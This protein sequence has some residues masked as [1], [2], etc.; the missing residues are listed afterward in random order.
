ME[1]RSYEELCYLLT[2]DIRAL[3]EFDR[4]FLIV[5]MSGESRFVG[6]S[7]QPVLDKKSK[8]DDELNR[9]AGELKELKKPLLLKSP[10]DIAA[11]SDEE[12]APDLKKALAA[13]MQF[14]KCTGVLC[15]PLNY[16]EEILGHL[17]LESLDGRVPDQIKIIALIKLVPFFSTALAQKWIF[18]RHPDLAALTQTPSWRKKPVVAFLSRYRLT[19]MV[20]I[21]LLIVLFSSLSRSPI[22]WGE[23]RILPQK[24]D[25]SG[26]PE[27]T[28]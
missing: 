28:V 15:V 9:L 3:I 18:D 27:W 12:L 25:T 19:L 14:A 8:F 22:R 26:S 7:N 16:G 10:S 1:A 20:V 11:L 23:R 24:I 5:H 2:N 13:Y 4:S 21:P 17:L 6:A